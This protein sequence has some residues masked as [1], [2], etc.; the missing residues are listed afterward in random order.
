MG[1]TSTSF[2]NPNSRSQTMEM[3]EKTAV[4]RT[5]MPRM[6]GNMNS[7]YLTSPPPKALKALCR[8]VPSR[9]R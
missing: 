9:K 6:P 3:A 8:P 5:V 7:T 1:E 4:K 2:K